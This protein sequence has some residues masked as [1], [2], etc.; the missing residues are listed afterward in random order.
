[1]SAKKRFIANH[2]GQV[3]IFI[4]IAI[5]IIAIAVLA[6]FFL[7]KLKSSVE[8]KTQSPNEYIQ[9]C[10]SQKIS[11]TLKTLSL[12]GGS[13]VS[14]KGNSYFYLGN[15]VEYLCYTNQYYLSC[16]VQQPLLIQHI[17]SE[18]KSNIQTDVDSCFA[19]LLTSYKNSGYEA[20]LKNPSTETKVELL[21]ERVVVSFNNELT[22]TKGE[23]QTFG[24][25][26][27]ILNTN[28]YQE[29]TIA[30]SITGWEEEFG[31]APISDYMDWY[32]NLKIELV[33]ET[34]GSKIYI[35]TDRNFGDKLQFATR[36]MALPPGY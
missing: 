24:N 17:E 1:M 13:V 18:V 20:S 5:L 14:E 25:F 7:P 21:P 3:T 11:D 35:I 26:S 34:D 32:P 19:S 16:V 33:R 28:I 23:S 22:V 31:S 6:Y 2:K 27:V 4:I 29:A 36:S 10:I 12:N 30:E 15:D 9:T 8:T